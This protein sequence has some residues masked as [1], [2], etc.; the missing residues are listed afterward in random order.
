MSSDLFKATEQTSGGSGIWIQFSWLGMGA[1]MFP[2]ISGQNSYVKG[3]NLAWETGKRK[4]RLKWLF[5]WRH[6][7]NLN[8]L[9]FT[10]RSFH[11]SILRRPGGCPR[12]LD[13]VS[14][15]K[16]CSVSLLWKGVQRRELELVG[17]DAK[18]KANF[19][20]LCRAWWARINTLR[21]E[22]MQRSTLRKTMPTCL[23][24]FKGK[25]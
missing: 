6:H 12:V 23:V 21:Q 1:M 8:M 19:L 10:L 24:S 11:V 9:H 22:D 14:D 25:W 20:L 7:R 13:T 17:Q 3:L 15:S 2:P 5:C 18:R 16:M 4:V